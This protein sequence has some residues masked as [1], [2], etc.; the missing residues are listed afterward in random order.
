MGRTSIFV[1]LAFA[2][3]LLLGQAAAASSGPLLRISSYTTVPSDVYPGTHGYLQITV[4]N[5]GDA[6]AQSVSANYNLNGM[7]SVISIGDVA[8]SSTAQI[9]VPFEIDQ[10]SAGSIQLINV[11]IYYS[12]TSGNSIL[13]KTT[14]LSIPLTVKQYKALDIALTDTSIVTSP[15]DKIVFSLDIK[16][17]GGVINNLVIGTPNDASFTL[18]GSTEKKIGNIPLNSTAKVA[19]SMVSSSDA[20]TGT[21]AIPIIFTYQDALKQ[22]TNETY[23][24]G[25]ITVLESSSK[26]RLSLTPLE[27]VEIGAQVPFQLTL[28]NAGATP[29]SGTIAINTTSV[30]TP[31][32]VQTAY[33]DSVPAGQSASK[34]VTIGISSSASSGYYTLPLTLTTAEGQKASYMSGVV[35]EATPEITVSLDT[36]GATSQIQVANTG[37]SQIRSVHVSATAIGSTTPTESFIGTLNVDDY[38][39]VA[40]PSGSGKSVAVVVTFKDSNN[41]EHTAKQ[42]LETTGNVS[43]VQGG[44]TGNSTIAN[45]SPAAMAGGPNSNPLGMLFGGRAGTA[46]SSGPNY[47]VIGIVVVVVAAGGFLAYRHFK[48]GKKAQPQIAAHLPQQAAHDEKGK[49]R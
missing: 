46:A 13:P 31:I 17:T 25:P 48:K 41:A 32:G 36:T 15:G 19:L 12:Y 29:M 40:L 18:Y 38:S 39:S 34:T 8:S 11:G 28:E 5:S 3:V 37:N 26:Y 23:Y 14:S 21:Y 1:A 30:F 49:K 27:T 16:N 35:V 7:N 43:F 45:G 44:R 20:K 2:F 47:V 9:A 33:F 4:E 42:T 10:S 6:T 22:P 24:L